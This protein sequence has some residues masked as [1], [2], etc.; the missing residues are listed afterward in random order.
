LADQPSASEVWICSI[1]DRPEKFVFDGQKMTKVFPYK[2]EF[3]GSDGFD[4]TYEVLQN[5]AYGIIA[6]TSAARLAKSEQ[7]NRD[8]QDVSAEV[9]MINKRG[10]NA[11]IFHNWSG[12]F[13]EFGTKV[14]D[15]STEGSGIIRGAERCSR[16]PHIKGSRR[17]IC[18]SR[19]VMP[20]V[21][22]PARPA[23]CSGNGTLHR[24]ALDLLHAGLQRG[25][26]HR[27]K[28]KS[29]RPAYNEKAPRGI[30]QPGAT[31]VVQIDGGVRQLVPRRFR[32]R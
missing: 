31:L 10:K 30:E 20:H 1:R 6:V 17:N 14:P 2:E 29:S 27:P 23:L 16:T 13:P 11:G 21:C 18:H 3:P 32:C 25:Q 15:K 5:N 7:G 26:Q 19:D 22:S 4:V 12:E 8:V 9:L 24:L 28:E